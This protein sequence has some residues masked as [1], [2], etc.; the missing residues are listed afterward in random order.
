MVQMTRIFIWLVL[1]GTVFSCR[2]STDFSGSNHLDQLHFGQG[3]GFSGAVRY[4]VLVRDGKLFQRGQ[5]DT[6]FT[7][8]SR[9]PADFTQ[10]LFQSYQALRLDTVQLYEPGDL[11]YFIEY[12]AKS[13][14]RHRIVWGRSGVPVPENITRYYNLLY[15]ST[16]AKS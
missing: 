1:A 6:S 9:W 2:S 4:F 13:S 8:I 7:F 12:R 3:G 16:K 5:M 10:Q 15:K 11:Y 14:G